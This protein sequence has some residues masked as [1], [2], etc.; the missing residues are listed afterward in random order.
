M[1]QFIQSYAVLNSRSQLNYS[2]ENDIFIKR[3]VSSSIRSACKRKEEC[4]ERSNQINWANKQKPKTIPR[5]WIGWAGRV[6]LFA[7]AL[8]S[9]ASVAPSDWARRLTSHPRIGPLVATAAF[10][11]RCLLFPPAFRGGY[12]LNDNFTRRTLMLLLVLATT[13][14]TMVVFALALPLIRRM[15]RWRHWVRRSPR[16]HVIIHALAVFGAALFLVVYPSK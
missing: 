5:R 6:W 2:N 11:R 10:N 7:R 4:N 1:S 8:T 15:R 12:S 16:N 14:T 13:R 3:P 9:G